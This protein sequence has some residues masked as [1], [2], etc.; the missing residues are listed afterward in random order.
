MRGMSTMR[1]IR[2]SVFKLNQVDF[3]AAIGV[4]QSTV[5][6]WENGAEPDRADLDAIRKAAAQRNIKWKDDWFFTPTERE[7]AA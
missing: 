1:H 7:S 6:R 3:A 4:Q 2:K 5:S